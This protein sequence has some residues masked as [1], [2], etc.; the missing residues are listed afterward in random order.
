MITYMLSKGLCFNISHPLFFFGTNDITNAVKKS[1]GQHPLSHNPEQQSNIQALIEGSLNRALTQFESDM[2]VYPRLCAVCLNGTQ[3]R[4]FDSKYFHNNI[5]PLRI[6]LT[7]FQDIVKR[8]VLAT[9]YPVTHFTP[10]NRIV[11]L[12]SSV[13]TFIRIQN[14]HII[15]KSLK[16]LIKSS[17]KTLPPSKQY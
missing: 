15:N 6:I 10:Q 8:A 17:Y 7:D 3:V 9:R 13:L 11:C 4:C 12:L 5:A 16:D 2:L 1:P 14:M